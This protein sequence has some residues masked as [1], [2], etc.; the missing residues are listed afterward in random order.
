MSNLFIA[1]CSIT[2]NI[3]STS[4]EPLQTGMKKID[5]EFSITLGVGTIC[6]LHFQNLKLARYLGGF[7]FQFHNIYYIKPSFIHIA[8]IPC[9]SKNAPWNQLIGFSIKPTAFVNLSVLGRQGESQNECYKKTKH[10]KYSEKG[11][12][13]TPWCAQPRAY[14]GV[15]NACFSQNLPCLVFL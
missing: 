13:L 2:N 7:I 11:T 14:Q 5:L 1:T 8:H 15:R 6:F 4:L 9:L 10:A 3:M 12:F